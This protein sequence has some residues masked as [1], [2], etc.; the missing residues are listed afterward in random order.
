MELMRTQVTKNDDIIVVRFQGTADVESVAG[1]DYTCR[2]YF[3]EKKIIFNLADLNFVGSSGLSKLMTTIS[4]MTQNSK[5]KICSVGRE[6]QK[7]F[8]EGPTKHLHIYEDE[9]SAKKAFE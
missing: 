5:L 2:K 9:T 3:L 7:V 1:F 8:A 6:L 4:S